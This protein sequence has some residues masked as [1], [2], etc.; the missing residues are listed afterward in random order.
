MLADKD[1]SNKLVLDLCNLLKESRNKQ[2]EKRMIFNKTR[3]YNCNNIQIAV[4]IFHKK[5][6]ITNIHDKT[7]CFKYRT[8]ELKATETNR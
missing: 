2:G 5:N 6:S 4:D 7:I 8:R 3:Q 1:P